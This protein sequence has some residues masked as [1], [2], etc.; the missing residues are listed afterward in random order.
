MT[1]TGSVSTTVLDQR[2]LQETALA[3]WHIRVM[4]GYKPHGRDRVIQIAVAPPGQEPTCWVNLCLEPLAEVV[5]ALAEVEDSV[6]PNGLGGD[7]IY[8]FLFRSRVHGREDA[9]A[10]KHHKEMPRHAVHVR[11]ARAA[12][13]PLE[14]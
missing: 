5:E 9:M 8:E 10:F 14:K 13:T 2:V 11:A 6:Y 12:A 7:A 1:A 4:P 3:T